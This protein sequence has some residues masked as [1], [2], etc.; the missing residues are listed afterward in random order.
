M[1]AWRSFLRAHDTVMRVLD[2]ELREAH[3]ITISEFDV[4]VQLSRVERG[5]MRM[6]DLARATLFSPSGL[7]RVCERLERLGFVER[8]PSAD[9]L[10]GT[11]AVITRDGAAR[12]R[13]AS[14]T[15]VGGS[16]HRSPTC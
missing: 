6:R 9:D 2:G 1:D 8:Q 3:D 15:H 10:R 13:R 14:E 11:E 4:L 12:L 16:A 7:T 5:R